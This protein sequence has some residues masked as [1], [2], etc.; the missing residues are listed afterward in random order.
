MVAGIC[1]AAARIRFSNRIA[2]NGPPIQNV[3]GRGRRTTGAVGLRDAQ[4]TAIVSVAVRT[5][6]HAAGGND[7][8]IGTVGVGIGPVRR[9][10]SRQIVTVSR[11]RD[12]LVVHVNAHAQSRRRAFGLVYA[13]EI[14]Q[15]IGS[16]CRWSCIIPETLSP[17]IGA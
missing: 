17:A 2:G 8:V 1:S 11:G 12:N 14:V 16:H 13:Q 7:A 3:D 4:P 5:T 10:V 9:T 15:G 6:G